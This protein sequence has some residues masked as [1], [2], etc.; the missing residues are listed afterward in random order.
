MSSGEPR[1][2]DASGT[3]ASPDEESRAPTPDP[4][5][6]SEALATRPSNARFRARGRWL[7]VGED[8]TDPNDVEA[9][10]FWGTCATAEYWPQDWLEPLDAFTGPDCRLR[11]G[12]DA[13]KTEMAYCLVTA[14]AGY[15]FTPEQLRQWGRNGRPPHEEAAGALAEA[16]VCIPYWGWSDLA[17]HAGLTVREWVRLLTVCRARGWRMARFFN[18]YSDNG[19][20]PLPRWLDKLIVQGYGWS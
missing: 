17:L 8:P 12:F 19:T 4:L 15:K 2:R 9:L 20:G 7:M 13:A 18:A 1:S 16:A 5:E 3:C 11:P 6:S 10:E 14:G